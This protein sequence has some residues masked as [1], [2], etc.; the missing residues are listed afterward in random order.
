MSVSQSYLGVCSMREM[1]D[2]RIEW[3]GKIPANWEICRFKNVANIFTGNSIKDSEKD[4]YSE[5]NNAIPYI[6]TKDITKG[7]CTI[8]YDNGL[9]TNKEDYN[10]RKAPLNSTLMCIEGGSAG[11]KKAK[12]NQEVSFV[13]KLCCFNGVKIKNDYLY[14]FL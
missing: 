1:K 11:I 12:T 14:Y 8:D 3:I 2:S 5:K 7:F 9:Y 10:F 6:S 4:N 13:N